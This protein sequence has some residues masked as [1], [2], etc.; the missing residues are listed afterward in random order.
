MK[1]AMDWFKQSLRNLR[2][3]EINFDAGLY[4]EVCYESHQAAEKAIKALLNHLGYEKRG[5]SLLYLVKSI[6]E[7]GVTVPDDVMNC[8]LELDKHY[9]PSRYPD[10]F[11]EGSPMD[12]YSVND[13]ERCLNCAR[14]IV[15]WVNK[16]IEGNALR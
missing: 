15:E 5:H 11:D 16:F 6:K 12:Y 13:G 14:K 7:S 8:I 9:I 3:A 10:V 1:R 2:S 4:E